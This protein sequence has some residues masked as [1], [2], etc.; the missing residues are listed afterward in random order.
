MLIIGVVVLASFLASF[1]DWL[2]FDVL[3][4]RY[5]QAAPQLWRQGPATTRI[6]VSQIIGTLASAAVVLLCA[7]LP[8]QPLLVAGAAWCAGPLP[9]GLQ[10]LQWMPLH[11]AVAASHAA[12]WLAR[13]L[14]AAYL[15]AWLLPA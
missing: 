15:A 6:V 14:I 1:T 11:P 9:V 12:G 7:R 3:V 2:C 13:L 5:Y 8:G 4:H 10:T